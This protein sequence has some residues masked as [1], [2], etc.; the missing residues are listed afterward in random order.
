MVLDGLIWKTKPGACDDDPP[1]LKRGPWSTTVTSWAPRCVSSSASA[2]PTTPDP[3]M[4]IFDVAVYVL[5]I[6]P[7]LGCICCNLC[8]KCNCDMCHTVYLGC[9]CE[10]KR[11]GAY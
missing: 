10:H 5:A 7:L 11:V 3:I 9:C 1:V 2:A 6:F 4:I 8:V